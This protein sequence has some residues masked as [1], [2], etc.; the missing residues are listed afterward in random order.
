[1]ACIHDP[2]FRHSSRPFRS[3]LMKTLDWSVETLG[4]EYTSRELCMFN[5]AN[6]S[7]EQDTSNHVLLAVSPLPKKVS[8]LHYSVKL[9][10]LYNIFFFY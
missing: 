5:Y 8:S 2:T 3:P 1:M 10:Y 6:Q 9:V 7:I 4:R